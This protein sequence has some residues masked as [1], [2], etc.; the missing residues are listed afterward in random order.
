MY[1]VNEYSMNETGYKAG[2]HSDKLGAIVLYQ[3]KNTF[4]ALK[5]INYFCVV[6]RRD[7]LSWK[8]SVWHVRTV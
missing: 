6:C 8:P 1:I 2:F 4:S 5:E 7:D 3:I